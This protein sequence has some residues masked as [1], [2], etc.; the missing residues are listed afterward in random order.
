VHADPD[1]GHAGPPALALIDRERRAH[2]GCR[3][4]VA[5]QHRVAHRLHRL[6]AML[7]RDLADA[8][9]EISREIGGVPITV[10]LG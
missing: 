10:S 6:T 7:A 1:R 2:R 8:R 4:G 3:G 9:G 5:E